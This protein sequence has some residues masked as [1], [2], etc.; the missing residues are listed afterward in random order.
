MRRGP[1][2]GP[3]LRGEC[4][5]KPEGDRTGRASPQAR[6]NAD[7]GA[8]IP[9]DGG[10]ARTGPPVGRIASRMEVTM[11]LPHGRHSPPAVLAPAEIRNLG[12]G[13]G[14]RRG[15]SAADFPSLPGRWWSRLPLRREPPFFRRAPG[16]S[17][18]RTPSHHADRKRSRGFLPRSGK[19]QPVPVR[20]DERPGRPGRS[21]HREGSGRNFRPGSSPPHSAPAAPRSPPAGVRGWAPRAPA[22]RA[23]RRGSRSR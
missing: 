15:L 9:S 7:P 21:R 14:R 23:A 12:C 22:S 5:P 11:R 1:S 8:F 4:S 10:I 16:G 2:A 17:V 6:E 3:G 18:G 13:R 20:K 19:P